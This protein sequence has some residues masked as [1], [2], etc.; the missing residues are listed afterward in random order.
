MQNLIKLTPPLQQVIDEAAET[1][2]YLWQKGW[3][4]Y[5]GGNISVNV[6]QFV[7][8]PEN[9]RSF[10]FRKTELSLQNLDEQSFFITASGTRM[11]DVAKNPRENSFII[12]LSEQLHGY[13]IL[14]GAVEN[15]NLEPSSELP[16]HL[17][18]HRFLLMNHRKEKVIVH[19]HPDELI[20]LTH[21]THYNR[22]DRL[23]QL[24]WRM[25]PEAV[26]ANPGGIG[27]VPYHKPGSEEQANAT[28]KA[29]SNHNIVLWEKHGC[30]AV[31][32][33][34][35]LAFD[36]ID[37]MNKAARIFFLCKQ[38]GFEPEGIPDEEIE[39]LRRIFLDEEDKK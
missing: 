29:L 6:S 4:E 36:R 21:I 28:V 19:T 3:A 14:W 20:A 9:L 25:I 34:T 38:A 32:E 17:G 22:E 23:N 30:L 37:S 1:A 39:N 16:S 24:L 8:K 33:S 2:Q 7:Q 11:R 12:Y 26:F 10:P 35:I 13:Y 18:I 27:L 15:P 31:A 5:N